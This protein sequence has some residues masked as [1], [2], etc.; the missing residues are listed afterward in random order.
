MGMDWA[1]LLLPLLLIIKISII[2]LILDVG[3]FFFDKEIKYKKLFNY[4]NKGRFCFF[5]G[6]D[7]KNNMVLCFPTRL[8][9]RKLTIFLSIIGT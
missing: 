8:Y 4:S 5:R 3:C 2:A 6:N 1:Y 9:F 7:F